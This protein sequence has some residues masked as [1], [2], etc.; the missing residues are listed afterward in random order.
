[1]FNECFMQGLITL[2]P[3]CALFGVW[4]AHALWGECHLAMADWRKPI[5]LADELPAHHKTVWFIRIW[6]LK[7]LLHSRSTY[8]RVNML[9]MCAAFISG[10]KAD[11]FL[12]WTNTHSKQPHIHF[13]PGKPDTCLHVNH[14]YRKISI[15]RMFKIQIFSR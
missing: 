9:S 11:F 15:N 13:T 6:S 3:W 4:S 2:I 12:S 7:Q 5:D 14:L 1:M 10:W 8:R